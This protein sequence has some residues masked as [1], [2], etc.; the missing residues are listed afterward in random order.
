MQ[1]SVKEAFQTLE[2]F[3]EVIIVSAYC[4]GRGKSSKE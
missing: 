4:L 3:L 1:D 2:D